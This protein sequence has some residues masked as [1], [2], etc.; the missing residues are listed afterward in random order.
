[1]QNQNTLSNIAMPYIN[2]TNIKNLLLSVI[3]LIISACATTAGDNSIEDTLPEKIV[4]ITPPTTPKFQRDYARAISLIQGKKNRSAIRSLTL[5]TQNYPQFA[6]PHVNLGLIFFKAKQYTKARK[7]FEKALV[8]NPNNAVS[9]NHIGIIQR[10]NGEFKQ[11]LQSYKLAIQSNANY[12]SAHLNI[13]ILYDIYLSD[14]TK[15]LEH[16]Q[17]YQQITG[18]KDKKVAKW[19]IDIKRRVNAS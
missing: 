7:E 15:A 3:V 4:V 6:G 17:R 12:A 5:L 14:L 19:I 2:S 8:L 16:Y 11:A 1:M 13:G 10:K 9:H 18:D